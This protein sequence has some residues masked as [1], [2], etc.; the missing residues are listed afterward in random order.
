MYVVNYAVKQLRFHKTY[1]T[2]IRQVQHETSEPS[3]QNWLVVVLRENA[4][5][6]VRDPLCLWCSVVWG[7]LRDNTR[8]YFISLHHFSL[9]NVQRRPK[10]TFQYA[11][12]L[13]GF[14]NIYFSVF[15]VERDW[16]YGISPPL[17]I[18]WGS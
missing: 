13:A 5:L 15:R 16:E 3:I 9:T 1:L 18:P 2:L 12:I 17:Y 14:K 10:G 11:V 4:Q 8:S 6:R 7:S